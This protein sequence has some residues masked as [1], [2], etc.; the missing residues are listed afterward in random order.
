MK[1]TAWTLRL[2]TASLLVA[3]A[4]VANARIWT[5]TD[6]K[7][8]KGATFLK[9]E[10]GKIH[11]K[12]ANNKEYAIAAERFKKNDIKAAERFQVLGDDSLT[13][14]SAERIDGLL[15]K[16][17]GKAGFKD[18]GEPLPDDL[19]VRRVYLDIIGRI[20]TREEFLR[21]VES[22]Y[23]DKREALI[24]ELLL[25]PGRASHLFNYF[26]DMYRLTDRGDF[27]N[28]IRMEPYTQWWREQLEANTPYHE[29]VSNMITA[30]GNVGQN[31]AAGFLLR[32]AG[33]E[34][35]A[36][37]NFG[38]VML[39]IDISCAQCHDHPFEDW[40]MDDFYEMAAFFGQTQ[41]TLRTASQAMGMGYSRSPMPGAPEGWSEEFKQYASRQGVPVNNPQQSRQFRY[42]TDFLGWNLTDVDELEIPVPANIEDMAGDTPR[43]RVLLGPAAKISGKTRREGLAEW[44]TSSEN[45]RFALSIANRMWSQAF[46]RPLVIEPVN[47]FP[48]E[49]QRGDICAQPEALAFLAT[50]M[51]RVGFDLREFMRIIYN[52]RVYQSIAIAEEPSRS[53]PYH[54]RQPI[55][56]RMRAEQA[57]DSLMLLAHGPDIDQI[58]G[59]DGSFLKMLLDVDFENDSMADI[60][61]KYE[62][63]DATR[64]N[65]MGPAMAD[66]DG[67]LSPKTAEVPRLGRLELVRASAT[68]QPAPA[69]S[70]LDTFGQSDRMVTDK[71]TFDGSVP[72][73]LA[74]MNGTVTSHLTGY[75][76]KLAD[77]LAK[78]DDPRSKV[79]KTYFTVLSRFPET[80]ETNIGVKIIDE[81][82]D[83]GVRDLVWALI[84]SPEFLFIQ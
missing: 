37:A 75:N 55:L 65:R 43:P 77:E 6:G 16:N 7:Q 20:P 23:K 63:F 33:M 49:W 53:K 22:A 2:L 76:N 74:L 70:L 18:Y 12:M 11:L 57:W 27:A 59:R 82:G 64:G 5:S 17:L 73:V 42:Y 83:D 26:A 15:A 71:H 32:D 44:L 10:D 69:A 58:K 46:G 34:F 67:S 72:Q 79:D 41:R 8:I 78:I 48:V 60:F 19:F 38:Q 9:Y 80:E 24:D 28:G 1:R 51:H 56:R 84:N 52:T 62:A 14:K 68:E 13:M 35:D 21:F 29:M 4:T 54:H 30:T 39:G 81:Y 40:V 3:L 61:A 47:N 66:E 45:P 50:E 25:H 36:F 31:P